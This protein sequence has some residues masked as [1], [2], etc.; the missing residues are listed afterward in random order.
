MDKIEVK[1]QQLLEEGQKIINERNLLENKI[2]QL[3]RRLIEIEGSIVTL[4][5]LQELNEV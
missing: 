1:T 5:E 4:R 2:N 3:N